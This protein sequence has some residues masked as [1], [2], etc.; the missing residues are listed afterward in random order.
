[1]RAKVNVQC[2]APTHRF[3]VRKHRQA[4]PLE[5]KIINQALDSWDLNPDI[6]RKETKALSQVLEQ[7]CSSL[8]VVSNKA[9]F[10]TKVLTAV[11]AKRPSHHHVLTWIN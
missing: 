11:K 4:C 9:S 2:L 10:K 1:M 5:N 8:T 6:L 7:T 3:R